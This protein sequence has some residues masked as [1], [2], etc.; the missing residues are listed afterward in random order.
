MPCTDF[1]LVFQDQLFIDKCICHLICI[2]RCEFMK[3][4][5]SHFWKADKAFSSFYCWVR[6]MFVSLV[7]GQNSSVGSVLGSLS[8]LMQHRGFHPPLRI[9]LAGMFYT[10][11][12]TSCIW[13]EC[14]TLMPWHPPSGR[15]VLHWCHDILHL[16]GMFITDAMT[17]SIWQECLTLMPWHPPSGR[18]V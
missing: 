1:T 18:D 14:L 3:W 6:G 2:K 16:A 15:G 4:F 12:I 17:S 5:A 7:E 8:C 11:A 10:D 9:F 13:Q